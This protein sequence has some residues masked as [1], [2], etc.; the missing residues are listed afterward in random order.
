MNCDDFYPMFLLYN[1]DRLTGFG[2]VAQGNASSSRYEHPPPKKLGVSTTRA[3][4]HLCCVCVSS[5]CV[6]VRVPVCPCMRMW[7]WLAPA[8]APMSFLVF[9]LY[10]P[11]I[12]R[13]GGLYGLAL[14]E[15]KI[16][17]YSRHE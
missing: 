1:S 5:E 6:C 2:W 3:V 12:N 10:L 14:T 16:L 13:T 15:F 8:P 11:F 17:P 4:A 7:M 9:E